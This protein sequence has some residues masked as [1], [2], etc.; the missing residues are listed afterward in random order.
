MATTWVQLHKTPKSAE[1]T[2]REYFGSDFD[3][4]SSY[5]FVTDEDRRKLPWCNFNNGSA[6]AAAA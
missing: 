3:G 2:G 6:R 4:M 1:E 5:A